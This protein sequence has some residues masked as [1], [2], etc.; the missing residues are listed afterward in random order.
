MRYP[1]A[2]TEP[3][4]VIRVKECEAGKRTDMARLN[5]ETAQ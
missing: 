4:D 1:D 5:Q 2:S 3:L